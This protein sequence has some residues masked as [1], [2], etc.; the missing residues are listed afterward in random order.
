MCVHVPR[1]LG[2]VFLHLFIYV[3]VYVRMSRCVYPECLCDLGMCVSGY[4]YTCD[5]Y[6]YENVQAR[7]CE[8]ECRCVFPNERKK[9]PYSILPVVRTVLPSKEP[10][11]LQLFIPLSGL[12]VCHI[13]DYILFKLRN[14]PLYL[15]YFWYQRLFSHL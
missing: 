1:W 10:R 12:I 15:E 8:W 3:F 2:H 13:Y 14:F 6:V 4:V 11:P 9:L 5:I 7:V